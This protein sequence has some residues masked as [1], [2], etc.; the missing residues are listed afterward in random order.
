V[1][2]GVRELILL[3]H[4]TTAFGMDWDGKSHLPA[5]L[6]TVADTIP[7]VWIRLLYS[8]PIR[9]D[10]RLLSVMREHSNICRYLDVPMQHVSPRILGLMCRKLI[11]HPVHLWQRWR[12][13]L[14]GVAIRTTL[15]AGFPG[16]TADEFN[17]LLDFVHQAKPDSGGVFAYSP[18]RGTV[19]AKLPGQIP[20]RERERRARLVG[21]AMAQT[22]M[23][24]AAAK[25]GTVLEVIVDTAET[26]NCP[27]VGR[28]RAQ[29]P[30][31]DGVTYLIGR[32]YTAGEV[33]TARI[34]QSSGVDLVGERA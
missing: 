29:A 13:E 27:A 23:Q 12:E 20:K 15:M 14:P 6:S 10:A 3:A 16:E 2:S 11:L 4:D 24:S 7:D 31:V 33:V 19:A 9:V 5:L 22:A 28:T 34:V 17:A 18:E 25:V 1:A 8:H 21:E 32:G 30:D 26:C